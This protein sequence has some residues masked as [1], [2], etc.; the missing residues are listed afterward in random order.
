MRA[1]GWWRSSARDC[2][3]RLPEEAFDRLTWLAS[4]TLDAPIAL[5]TLLT[6]TRQW[7]K[8]RIGLDTPETPRSWA[9]CNHTIL[10]KAVFSVENLPSDPRLPPTRPSG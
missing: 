8:S 1:R 9:F 10:Q 3:R 7:F 6:P 5:L 2:W 4:R